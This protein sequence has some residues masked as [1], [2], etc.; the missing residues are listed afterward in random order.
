MGPTNPEI[1]SCRVLMVPSKHDVI[2]LVVAKEEE[3]KKGQR[4]RGK[5]GGRE[6]GCHI[7]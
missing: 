5:D 1:M 3:K 6:E 4:E 2:L 7:P